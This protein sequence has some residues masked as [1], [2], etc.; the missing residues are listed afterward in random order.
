MFSRGSTP[1]QASRV[2]VKVRKRCSVWADAATCPDSTT[3]SPLSRGSPWTVG[4]LHNWALPASWALPVSWAHP[5]LGLLQSGWR[6]HCLCDLLFFPQPGSFSFPSGSAEKSQLPEPATQC[7]TGLYQG[8]ARFPPAF[9]PPG[10]WAP[11]IPQLRLITSCLAERKVGIPG[12][13]NLKHKVK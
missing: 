13:K 1:Q 12:L 10:P 4:T 7:T 6:G 9:C 5:I 2:F 8:R 11:L 3:H